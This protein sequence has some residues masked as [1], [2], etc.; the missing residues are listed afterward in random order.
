MME[1]YR[2]GDF[3]LWFAKEAGA[4]PPEATKATHPALRDVY[5][6]VALG[7]LF[8][9]SEYGIAQR[10][11]VPVCQGRRLL[12]HHKAVFRRFWCWSDAI[13]IVGMLGGR[14][15]T[16]FGWQVSTGRDTTG[17][18]VRNFPMQA[19]GAEM[20]RLACCLAVERG[21]PVCGLIHDALLVE[22]SLTDIEAV[23]Q[24]TQAAMQDAS[25]LVLPG[26]PLRTEASIV[27]YPD[28]YQD[29]RGTG[30]WTVVQALLQEAQEA[31]PF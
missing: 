10:L 2:S 8:G 24:Q 11:R 23:V 22:A 13:E 29:S 5:K 7:V 1:A 12:E 26:F 4:A 17:R 19:G 14:V 21:I 16:A 6:V 28:R 30:M 27:R 9:L 15:R 20:L 3:Y 18:S 31:I 25:V